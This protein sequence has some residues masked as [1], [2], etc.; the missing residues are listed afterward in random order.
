MK[1]D[2][3]GACC[4]MEA[5]EEFHS[6]PDEDESVTT[7]CVYLNDVA[8]PTTCLKTSKQL[9]GPAQQLSSLSYA[10]R[11]IALRPDCL[12]LLTQD[13][14]LYEGIYCNPE[15]CGSTHVSF[16][17][18]HSNTS[19]VQFCNK[20]ER[21]YIRTTDDAIYHCSM[22]LFGGE[23][24]CINSSSTT[25]RDSEKIHWQRLQFDPLGLVEIE[26]CI[27]KMACLAESVMFI[28]ET[29]NIY[30]LEESRSDVTWDIN[31]HPK[32]VYVLDRA[33]CIVLDL[34]VGSNF[35]ALLVAEMC[36]DKCAELSN[37]SSTKNHKCDT[38]FVPREGD[39]I[40]S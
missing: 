32:L 10:L 26:I 12:L 18:L 6:K 19:D 38:K 35:F 17:L 11:F 27:K 30:S 29:G 33:A 34:V 37:T 31:S 15:K 9:I 4:S 3:G 24:G 14:R 20:Q 21:V 2:W 40:L 36:D 8:V 16:D 7:F 28:S 39:I 1:T 13:H 22:H 25:S 23:K 5:K